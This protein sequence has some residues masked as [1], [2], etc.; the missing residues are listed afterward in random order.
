MKMTGTGAPAQTAGER[1]Q[2]TSLQFPGHQG[3]LQRSRV[4]CSAQERLHHSGLFTMFRRDAPASAADSEQ[5]KKRARLE[6]LKAWKQQQ[7]AAPAAPAQ[8]PA[9]ASEAAAAHSEPPAQ[10]AKPA[11]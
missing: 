9:A 7:S 2:R 8:Q 4:R 1:R 11:W 5:D 3:M 10:S 6:K